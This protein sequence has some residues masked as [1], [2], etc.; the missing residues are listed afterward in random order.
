MGGIHR[1]EFFRHRGCD[2]LIDAGAVKLRAPL[3]FSLRLQQSLDQTADQLL[4]MVGA[5]PLL[6]VAMA[7]VVVAWWLGRLVGGRLRIPWL[8]SSNPYLDGLVRRLLQAAVVLGGVLVALDLLGASA[9]VGAVVGSAGLAGLVLGFAFRD[10]AEN[11]VAGVLLSLRRPFAPGDHLVVDSFEG[12][13][14]ALNAR[15]TL[16]MTLDGNH[17]TLPNALVFKSVVLNYSANPKRRF[18]FTTYI[19]PAQSIHRAR[20]V[21][22][23]RIA[24]VEG[25]L[26]DPGPSVVV[27]RHADNGGIALR[28]FGWVDQRR[29]DLAKVRGEALRVV[30][31][32]FEEAGIAG[33]RSVQYVYTAPAAEAARAEAATAVR[34]DAGAASDTSVNQDIDRQLADAQRASEGNMLEGAGEATAGEGRIAPVPAVPAAGSAG[35]PGA[36]R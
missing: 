15:N 1:C 34:E 23:A 24:A 27:E 8:D 7:V 3:D 28:V 14:V 10:I 4:R 26:D 22:V 31:A 11:Y 16:L 20:T 19:D 2:E 9:L 35:E 36:D 30:K 5:L 21:A 6:L 18:D 29:S 25:V 32:G 17:L 33:P 13:V 12:K